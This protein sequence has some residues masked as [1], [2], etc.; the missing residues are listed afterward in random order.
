MQA[1]LRLRHFMDVT[2]EGRGKW[3]ASLAYGTEVHSAGQ[4]CAASRCAPGSL[5]RP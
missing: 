1:W 2:R 4:W 3:Y 5:V